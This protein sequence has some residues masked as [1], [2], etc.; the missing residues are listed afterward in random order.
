MLTGRENIL[1]MLEGKKAEYTP[2]TL[3]DVALVGISTWELTDQPFGSGVDP[4]GVEWKFEGIGTIPDSRKGFLFE[5]IEDWKEYVHFPDLDAI[6]FHKLFESEKAQMSAED[7]NNKLRSYYSVTGIFERL[8]AFMGFEN[9]LISMCI[10][11]ESVMEFY[12]AFTDYKIKTI[13]KIIDA[14]HPDL[15]VFF[16]DIAAAKSTFMS[17]ETYREQ[18]KPFHKKICDFVHSKGVH[19]GIHTCGNISEIIDDYVEIGVE[20]WHT[21]QVMNPLA[22]IAEKYQGRLILDGGWDSQGRPGA[23]DATEQEIRDETRRSLKDYG[24]FGNF[25]LDPMVVNEKGN[26]TYTGDDRF[27]ALIEEWEKYRLQYSEAR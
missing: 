25:I 23:I 16:D 22:E 2:L 5:D 8:A 6:D 12:E 27:P 24:R 1:R 3:T 4:F 9:A 19:F 18:I 7:Y 13:D 20:Y 17:P 14:Y 21:A 26:A 10:D 11:P 15:V